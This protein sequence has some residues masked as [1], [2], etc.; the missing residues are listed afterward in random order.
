MDTMPSQREKAEAYAFRELVSHLKSHPEVQNMDLM[1]VSG[2]CRNC[3]AKWL[4]AGFRQQAPLPL[5]EPLTY[6]VVSTSVYGMPSTEWKKTHQLKA[7][8]EQLQLYE[9]S[10]AIHAKHNPSNAMSDVASLAG[11]DGVDSTVLEPCCPESTAAVGIRPPTPAPTTIVPPSVALTVGVL[12]ISDRV[13]TGV[14]ADESGP[15]IKRM[16]KDFELRFPQVK[17]VVTREQVVPDEQEDI[18]SV[19]R[20]WSAHKNGSGADGETLPS[21]TLMI[22]TGGT[23]LS[24]RDV[25]PEATMSVV[26]RLL[27]SLALEI[28]AAS[29]RFEPMAF[30][31]RGV[32]GVAGRSI[33][34]NVPGNPGAIKQYLDTGL[35]LLAHASAAL[36]IAHAST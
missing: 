11:N 19:L 27:P 2:F 13:A 16:L 15:T 9:A 20:E 36:A 4:L 31:S 29:F 21:C 7:T 24:S 1:T 10:K 8:K 14:Y 22:T 17:I 5:S 3:L 6:D 23:G 32:C 33:V 18:A 26:D 28:T 12:T 30:L 35:P 34:L 25:T